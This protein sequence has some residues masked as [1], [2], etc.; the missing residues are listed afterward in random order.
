MRAAAKPK[1]VACGKFLA[2]DR[3]RLQSIR[4][5]KRNCFANGK[6]EL[7][8]T[9]QKGKQKLVFAYLFYL[10]AIIPKISGRL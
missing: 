6:N 10:F 1:K 9:K 3:R 7:L 4:K 8:C 5:N 2:T